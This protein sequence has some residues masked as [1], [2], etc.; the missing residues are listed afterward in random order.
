MYLTALT[1]ELELKA[2]GGG[3]SRWVSPGNLHYGVMHKYPKLHNPPGFPMMGQSV[4]GPGLWKEENNSRR[5]H[6]CG[7]RLRSRDGP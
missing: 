4:S 6:R 1:L 5:G 2:L 3:V 7:M